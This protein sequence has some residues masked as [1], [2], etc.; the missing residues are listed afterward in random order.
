MHKGQTCAE[1][2]VRGK[3][4]RLPKEEQD[5]LAEEVVRREAVKCPGTGCGAN[6][7]KT[8]GCDHMICKFPLS[9]LFD[10]RLERCE[11]GDGGVD[12]RE[13]MGRIC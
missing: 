1:Y 11:W 6:I 12:E 7:Q 3:L 9:F 10:S 5:R 4:E 2:A 13:G 8:E